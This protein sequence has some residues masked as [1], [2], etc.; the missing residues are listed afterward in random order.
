MHMALSSAFFLFSSICLCLSV[1][2]FGA[3]FLALSFVSYKHAP[4]YLPNYGERNE[5]R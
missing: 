5:G 4:R 3:V 2:F 1:S